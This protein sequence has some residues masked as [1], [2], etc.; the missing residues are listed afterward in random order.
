MFQGR[1][2]DSP[3]GQQ[4]HLAGS[5]GSQTLA[6]WPSAETWTI[7]G[8]PWA[9]TLP[10]SND[11]ERASKCGLWRVTTSAGGAIRPAGATTPLTVPQL[12][13]NVALPAGNQPTVNGAPVWAVLDID[14]SAGVR[15]YLVDWGQTLEVNCNAIT[16]GWAAPPTWV[17]LQRG[18]QF[19]RPPEDEVLVELAGFAWTSRLEAP[20]AQRVALTFTQTYYV[21]AEN[22]PAFA[23]PR[24]AYALQVSRDIVGATLTG[25]LQQSIGSPALGPFRDLAGIR[26]ENAQSVLTSIAPGVTHIRP[27]VLAGEEALWTLQWLIAI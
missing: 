22:S 10:E 21:A 17:D 12:S 27:P 2:Q 26:Y 13:G 5:V 9:A 20:S 1:A 11:P 4:I 24:G 6:T 16:V 14:T 7:G 25:W 23:V 15:T 3:Q 19:P 18:S 8:R